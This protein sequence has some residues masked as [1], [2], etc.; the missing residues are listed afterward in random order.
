VPVD[1][2]A[3]ASV[4]EQECAA[5]RSFTT[6]LHEEQHSLI[7]AKFENLAA[8][9]EP[10]AKSLLELARL[11]EARNDLLMRG[12]IK[13]NRPAIEKYLS[14]Q[15]PASG[16]TARWS[17]LISLTESAQHINHING[18]LISTRL[19]STQKALNTLLSAAQLPQTYGHDGSTVSF[20][21]R[22]SLGSA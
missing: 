10:K 14:E 8:S 17:M 19:R 1:N 7:Q 12:E 21:S 20:R 9:A 15:D 16:L 3:L 5:L 22:H 2:E 6:L 18:T 4:L 13:T 11:A